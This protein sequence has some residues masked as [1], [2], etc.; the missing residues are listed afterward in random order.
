MVIL[1][2]SLAFALLVAVFALQNAN[3]V[4]IRFFWTEARVPLVLIILGSAFAGAIVTLLLAF[5]RDFRKKRKSRADENPAAKAGGGED[6]AEGEESGAIS[7]SK[8]EPGGK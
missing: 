6:G 5:W 1:I 4:A 7:G 2:L 8:H 3:P